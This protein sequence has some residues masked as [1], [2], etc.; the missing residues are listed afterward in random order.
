MRSG[1][2]ELA[3]GIYTSSSCNAGGHGIISQSIMVDINEKNLF[4]THV[5][6][7]L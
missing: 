1:L 4:L 5:V 2:V 3:S 7:K 6:Q